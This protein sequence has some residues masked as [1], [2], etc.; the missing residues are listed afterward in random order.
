MKFARFECEGRVRF[1]V[2]QEGE[3]AV[4]DGSLFGTYD[5]TNEHYLLSEVKLLPPVIPTKIIG[6]GRNYRQHIEEIGAKVPEKP[7]FFLKPPSSLIGHKEGEAAIVI[8]EEM[9]DIPEDQALNYVLGCSC[10]ND[11]TERALVAEN[12]GNLT[13]A[14]GFDTFSAFGPYVATDLDPND[15]DVK[16]YL[17]GNLMQH[18]NTMNCVFNTQQILHYLSQCMTLYPGDIVATGTPKGIAPMSPGDIVEVEVQ[19]VGMLRNTVISQ[20]PL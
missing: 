12:I 5:E 6:I 1:G 14:K 7:R 16:T 10:F 11:V 3:I 9:K 17:N 4:L 2:V 19:G 13:L 15:L 8:K 20:G 18:D